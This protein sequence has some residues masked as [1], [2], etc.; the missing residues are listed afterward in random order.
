MSGTVILVILVILVIFD[1]C[2]SQATEGPRLAGQ[3][4]DWSTKARR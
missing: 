2:D 1:N 4:Q 3:G